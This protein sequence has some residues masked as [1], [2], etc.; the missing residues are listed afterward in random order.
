[1]VK[2]LVVRLKGGLGNQMFQ[3]AMSR[4]LALRNGADLVLDTW[5]GFMRDTQYRRNYELGTLPIKGHNAN[6]LEVIP[7]FLKGF[8]D[9]L[10]NEC[11]NWL[12]NRPYGIFINETK[13][14]FLEEVYNFQMN[15]S[16]W[17]SGYWQSPKYFKNCEYLIEKELLPPEPADNKFAAL[18][19]KMHREQSVA[20]GI[21]LYEESND[22]AAHSRDGRI[23][24]IREINNVVEKIAVSVP[25]SVF[26]VFCTHKNRILKELKCPSVMKFIT[27]DDGFMGTVERLWLLTQCRHHIMN[28]SSFYWW[29]AWL[30]SVAHKGKKQ[31]VFAADN[32]WNKDILPRG[33]NL[34]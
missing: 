29:G 31:I 27:H 32:F 14:E 22:P 18:G 8:E 19:E 1:M 23:K 11:S 25:N 20:V 7:V 5:T 12:C 30:S 28:N 33:W 34:F 24:A 21:R 6:P 17:V 4:A 26:Y 13:F 10:V 3:Y 2:K 15:K 9:R 16:C